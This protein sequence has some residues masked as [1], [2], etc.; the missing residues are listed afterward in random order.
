MSCYDHIYYH[1]SMLIP[2]SSGEFGN[3]IIIIVIYGTLVK[4]PI[5]YCIVYKKSVGFSI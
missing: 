1:L 3:N 2:V 5:V 4:F